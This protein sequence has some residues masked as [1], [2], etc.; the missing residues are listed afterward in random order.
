MRKPESVQPQ[1]PIK[2]AEDLTLRDRF[3]MAAVPG[4]LGTYRDG[5]LPRDAFSIIARGAYLV[6]DAMLL[7]RVDGKA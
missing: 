5:A 4:I 1:R 7:A 6:A 2:S 3:A